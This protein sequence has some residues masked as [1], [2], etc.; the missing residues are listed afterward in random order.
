[1]VLALATAIA[2]EGN[3]YKYPSIPDGETRKLKVRYEDPK[4]SDAYFA[5]KPIN[6]RVLHEEAAASIET[7]ARLKGEGKNRQLV[8]TRSEILHNRVTSVWDLTFAPGENLI[9]T[10]IEHKAKTA[11]GKLVEQEFWDLSDPVFRYPS[12][13]YHAYALEVFF[14]SLPLK[15]GHKTSFHLWLA[16]KSVMRMWVTVEKVETLKLPA[17]DIECYCLQMTPNLEDF[18]GKPGKIIQ[19]LVPKYTFWLATK[20]S[21]PMV[22]YRG[23]LGEVNL[24]SAPIE[25]HELTNISPAL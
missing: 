20:G 6:Q 2:Q 7:L 21:H 3:V 19:P 12:D 15:T 24:V 1:M 5:S 13:T 14:R 10:S 25:V 16:P 4:F 17:G 22:K 23:P 18:L 8:Y 9:L 11:T